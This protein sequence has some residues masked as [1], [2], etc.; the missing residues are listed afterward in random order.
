[1]V[2]VDS[3]VWIQGLRRN[4]SLEVK[5]ALEGLLEAYEAQWC[6][7]VRLEVLGG[8]RKVE[9][10][11]I[12]HY[13]TVVP[14]RAC[15]EEDWERALHIGWRLR[16]TGLNLPWNDVLIAAIAFRDGN[17]VYSIDKHFAAIAEVTGLRLYK[18][19]PGGRFAPEREAKV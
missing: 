3:C 17:R 18:P 6:S 4:G 2:L 7:P 19:G 8:A 15:D 1:M 9:R 11:R 10:R 13:F 12:S 16:D 14:Y 5:V